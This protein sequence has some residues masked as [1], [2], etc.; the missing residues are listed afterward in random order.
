MS[1]VHRLSMF[2]LHILNVPPFQ[3][4]ESTESSAAS[5]TSACRATF[6]GDIVIML[7]GIASTSFWHRFR[8]ISAILSHGFR[9]MMTA[10]PCPSDMTV[11]TLVAA[12]DAQQA[13][14]LL[15]V[16]IHNLLDLAGSL[17]LGL[18]ELIDLVLPYHEA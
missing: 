5:P 16:H 9:A 13:R 2:V 10:T 6:S 15:L 8:L 11:A 1:L 3:S 17:G 4:T 7:D 14:A 18:M 12:D